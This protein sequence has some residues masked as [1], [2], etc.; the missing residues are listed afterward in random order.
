MSQIRFTLSFHA[1]GA[2]YKPSK[3][4][5]AFASQ[6]DVGDIAKI[7]RYK[8]R[9]YPY[10][11]SEIRVADDL[12]WSE[13][14]P[15]LVAT[16]KSLL[17]RMKEKGADSFYVSAGYFYSGQGNLEFS[18]NELALLASLD[19]PFCPSCYPAEPEGVE[20]VK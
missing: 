10:G 8:G 18:S 14:I 19:C 5:F 6:N 2:Y 4:E 1:S 7:G 9:E 3:I 15:A 20:P 12:P 17:P 16:A 13:K 11:S